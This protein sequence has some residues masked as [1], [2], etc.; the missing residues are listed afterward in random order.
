MKLEGWSRLR[1]M[2]VSGCFLTVY[3]KVT[4]AQSDHACPLT[5]PQRGRV[6]TWLHR[7]HRHAGLQVGP[8]QAPPQD[9]A[10]SLSR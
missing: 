6:Q 9:A 3:S 10:R 8:H 4:V 5:S 1:G 2:Q 7:H